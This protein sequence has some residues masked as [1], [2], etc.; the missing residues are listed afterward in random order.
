MPPRADRRAFKNEDLVLRVS[1]DVDPA[2]WN[3]NRFEGYVDELCGTREYQKDALR[4]TLRYLLGGKYGCLRDLA[5]TNFDQSDDLQQRYG[6]FAGMER[7]LQLPDLLSCSI[8][9]A[10]GTG[11]SYVL[12]GLSAILLAQGHVDRVLVLC[13]STTIEAGLLEKFR[14]LA[15]RGELRDLLP[16]DARVR[17]PTILDAT[18]SLTDGSICV[19]N[20]HA[21]LSHVRSSI[22]DSLKGKGERTAVLCDEFHHVAN[23]AGAKFKEWKNFLCDPAFGFRMVVGVSGTC[24]VGDDYFAD[25]ISRYSLRQA[26]EER[27]VKQIEYVAE[28]PET[29]NPEEKWQLIFNRHQD[30]KKRLRPR[31]LKPLTVIITKGIAD[32]KRVA[33][34][35]RD[36]LREW[37]KLSP[38]DVEAAVSVV[39]S[40][41]EHQANL[42][43]LRNVDS[44]SSKVEWILSVSMLTEGWDVKNVFQIVPH[45]ERA[46]NSKLLI[47]QVLGRGLRVPDDWN[48]EPPVVTVF[49][50]DRWSGSIR[51]LVNEVLEIERRISSTALEKSKYNFELH[52]LDYSRDENTSEFTKRGEYNLLREGFVDLPTQVEEEEVAIK[53]NRAVSERQITYRT[54]IERKTY[55]VDEVAQLMFRRLQSVDEESRDSEEPTT[56]SKKLPLDRC[57]EI[58]LASLKR[59]NI[60]SGRITEDNRQRFLAALGTLHRKKAKRVVYRLR[61]NALVTLNTRERQA[62]SCSAAELRRGDRTVFHGPESVNSLVDVQREF[63]AEI[64]DPDGQFKAGAVKIESTVNFKTPLNLVITDAQPERRFVRNLFEPENAQAVDAWL[65]NVNQRFYWIE[66]AWRKGEHQ[67]RGEFSPDFFL[68]KGTWIFVVEVKGDEELSDPSVESR[69]KHEYALAHFQRVNSW[70]EKSGNETRYQLNFLTPKSFNA[71]F[72]KMRAGDL[73]GFRSELDVILGHQSE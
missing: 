46:F 14:E 21:V 60:R 52:T 64:A 15:G 51:H 35:L 4:T 55:A 34:E 47:A 30:W 40:A 12:F 7:H 73:V 16:R 50:H 71:F 10:T 67:K 17:V 53:F 5:R 19:E 26:I 65:K 58:V 28:M 59:A 1:T 22:A 31:K 68:K 69:R 72:Q 3:E 13:P 70:L 66:Y 38:E 36:F 42:A 56:Y 48:G 44:N 45:E 54:T 24:Y 2:R 11:K 23:E 29:T 43:T 61:P 41:K 57:R 25:V 32:C 37:G 18:Q 27:R 9:L 63:F 6:S 49:N 39:T 62:E 33:E 20:F 8:D